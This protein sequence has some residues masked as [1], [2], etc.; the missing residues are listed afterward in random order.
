[1]QTDK[2]PRNV[3]WATIGTAPERCQGRGMI[4]AV[5]SYTPRHSPSFRLPVGL[6][7]LKSPGGR[8]TARPR[9]RHPRAPFLRAGRDTIYDILPLVSSAEVIRALKRDG[10]S[11]ARVKGSHHHF[12][13]PTSLGSSR[14]RTRRR[15]S[16]AG[17]SRVSSVKRARRRGRRETDPRLLAGTTDATPSWLL[18]RS[19]ITT[20][21]ARR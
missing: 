2:I 16:H 4:G 21:P 3:M 18:R 8:Q 5:F 13:H 12:K 17:R 1:M 20:P 19:P 14:S 9:P 11:E 15:T 10:W 6:V 7:A